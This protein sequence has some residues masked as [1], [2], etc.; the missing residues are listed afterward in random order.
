[1]KALLTKLFRF[2]FSIALDTTKESIGT[3]KT[4]IKFWCYLSAIIGILLIVIIVYSLI[5]LL[6]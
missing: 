1:M 3:V 2:L 6:I 4:T 5:S